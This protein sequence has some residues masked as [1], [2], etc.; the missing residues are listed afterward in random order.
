MGTLRFNLDPFNTYKDDTLWSALEKAHLKDFV[1]N[2]PATLNY[3][4]KEGGGNLR[5]GFI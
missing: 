4:I 3:E 5:Y 2:L 1:K